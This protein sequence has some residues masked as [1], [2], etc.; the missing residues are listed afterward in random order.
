MC[1]KLFQFDRKSSIYFL[2]YEIVVSYLEHFKGHV[3]QISWGGFKNI[4]N[5]IIYLFCKYSALYI[6]I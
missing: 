4:I 5:I 1:L 3:I 6:F 2:S